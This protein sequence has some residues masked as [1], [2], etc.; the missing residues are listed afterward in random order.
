MSPDDDSDG[1]KNAEL[2]YDL[3]PQY[4]LYSQEPE[5]A[6]QWRTSEVGRMCGDE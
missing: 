1:V 3:L 6:R 4:S 2:E 5:V